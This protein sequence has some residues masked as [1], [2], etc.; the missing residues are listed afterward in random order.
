MLGGSRLLRSGSMKSVTS[1]R[2]AVS[3]LLKKHPILGAGGSAAC[4]ANL[5]ECHEMA[6]AWPLSL[7]AVPSVGFLRSP[8]RGGREE[9]PRGL[10]GCYWLWTKQQRHLRLAFKNHHTENKLF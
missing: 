3:T 6:R 7:S 5:Y 10:E 4:R 2:G 1:I 8:P 9:K